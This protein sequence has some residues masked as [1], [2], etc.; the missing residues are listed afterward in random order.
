MIN[1]D[2]DITGNQEEIT[3]FTN[4]LLEKIGEYVKDN[5]VT[6][7]DA[8]MTAHNVHKRVVDDIAKRWSIDSFP[9]DRTYRLADMTF[10]QAMRELKRR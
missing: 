2:G 10:R 8:F 7:I 4:W 3:K 5:Q 1:K 6:L 9:V